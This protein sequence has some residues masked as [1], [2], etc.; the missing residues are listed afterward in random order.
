MIFYETRGDRYRVVDADNWTEGVAASPPPDGVSVYA[1]SQI[2]KEAT[3]GGTA[4][5]SALYYP[6]LIRRRSLACLRTLFYYQGI[7][8]KCIDL[9]VALARGVS[10]Y[11][12]ERFQRGNVD[13]RCTY[14]GEHCL[15]YLDV[16]YDMLPDAE[17]MFEL[18]FPFQAGRGSA[19]FKVPRMLGEAAYLLGGRARDV[20]NGR[21]V[22]KNVRHEK[23]PFFSRQQKDEFGTNF[24]V[25]V[26]EGEQASFNER[27]IAHKLLL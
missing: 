23:T 18:C 24:S 6:Q 5:V 7:L 14:N 20:F 3:W 21:K 13:M 16:A 9:W 12:K 15:V 8:Y 22:L 10:D 26:F 2:D 17:I 4:T 27:E 25:T 1:C 11:P 19:E